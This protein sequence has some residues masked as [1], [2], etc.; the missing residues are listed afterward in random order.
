MDEKVLKIDMYVSAINT[1]E[2]TEDEF[3]KINQENDLG[4]DFND[5]DE[6]SADI[7]YS[8]LDDTYIVDSD[9]VNCYIEEIEIY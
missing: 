2:L 4:L 7:L 3:N 9:T 8:Y 6:R 5:L 1:Y